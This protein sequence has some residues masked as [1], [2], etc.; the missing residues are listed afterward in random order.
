MHQGD[1]DEHKGVY[2]IYTVDQITQFEA[3]V[4]VQYF[5]ERYLIPALQ[6]LFDIL[7]FEVLGFH[8]DNGCEYVNYRVAELLEKLRIEFTKS[9]ARHSID[10]A[11]VKCK[12]GHVLRKLLEHAHCAAELNEFHQRHLNRY[13]NY[14]RPCLF[15]QVEMDEQGRQ[16]RR[17][18]FEDVQTPYKKLKLLPDAEQF[19]KV[20]VTFENLDAFAV[21][22]SDNEAVDR[23]RA[24]RRKLFYS[25]DE[26]QRT[27]T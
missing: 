14:H 24:A 13:V 5:S 1:W 17:Y 7:S 2:H 18:Q 19:L 8:S 22:Y 9:R 15:A 6:Q 3:V 16:Q 10:N 23:L 12:N 11:L 25:T 27:Q 26:F 21:R 4:S 20:G